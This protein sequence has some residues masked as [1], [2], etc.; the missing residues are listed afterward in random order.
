MASIRPLR[1]LRY[2]KRNGNRLA[3]VLAPPYDVIPP[4]MKKA[5]L[6]ADPHNAIRLIVGNPSVETHRPA[7]YAAAAKTLKS[8]RT[9]GVLNRDPVPSIAVYQQVFRVDGKT[10]RR[11]GFLALDKLVPFGGRKGGI[12]PHEHTLAGPKADRLNLMKACHANFSAI[13]SLYSD[14]TGVGRMLARVASRKPDVCAEYPKGVV[15]RLWIVSDPAWVKTLTNRMK[16]ATLFIADGH[17][18]YETALAYQAFRASGKAQGPRPFDYVLMMFVAMEDPGLVILPTHRLLPARLVPDAGEVLGRLL[19]LGKVFEY[20]G[21]VEGTKP[22]NEMLRL[23]KK[24]PT[25]GFSPDGKKL[26]FFQFSKKAL[27][28]ERLAGLSSAQKGLDV[29]LLHRLILEPWFGVTKE[30]V[31]H[32]LTFS[33]IAAEAVKKLRKK[34]AACAFFLNPT[35][36]DQLR[37]VAMKQERMPQKSTFF[38]PKLITGLVFNDLDS[39]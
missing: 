15:N 22:W 32:D 4:K 35:R 38:Y 29:T 8:W 11:T 39:F 24:A 37:G 5:L 21:V 13:F 17:H 36:I 6:A 28:S 16:K 2:S 33:S 26:Y 1:A 27:R 30:R 19:T 12:L 20:P 14:R 23:G 18:R 25:L 31:E 7:D 34:E 10:Y 9:R 3:R